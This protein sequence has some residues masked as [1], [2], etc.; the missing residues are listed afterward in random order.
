MVIGGDHGQEKF[1]NVCKYI[2]G[3]KYGKNMTSY[4]IKNGHI[5]YKKDT[6]EIFQHTL[7][8]PLNNAKRL[9]FIF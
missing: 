1:R 8:T 5:D 7:V 9:L 6:Y 3:N 2:I 4:V